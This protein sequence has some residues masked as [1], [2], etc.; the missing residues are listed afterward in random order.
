MS[1]N[2]ILARE[3]IQAVLDLGVREFILC[4]GARNS[5]FV[6]QLEQTTGI[7]LSSFFEERSAGF[8]AMGRAQ[9]SKRPVCVVTTSGTA[10]AE[11]LPASVEATYCQVPL[12]WL[13]ADRPR[14]YR[15]TGAPQTIHQPGIFSSYVEK[16]VD[17]E[18]ISELAAI[19]KWSGHKPLHLNVCFDEPL[20]D[21]PV[22]NLTAP[23]LTS[24]FLRRTI[25]PSTNIDSKILQNPFVILS[26]MSDEA[27]QIAKRLVLHFGWLHYAE[28]PSQLRGDPELRHLQVQSGD[29]ILPFAFRKAGF[30]SV[31]RFGSVP[32]LRFWRDLEYEFKS[33]P[34]LNLGE[35][36][37]SGL[38]R[39][40]QTA[41]LFSFGKMFEGDKSKFSWA[42]KSDCQTALRTED[43]RR[44]KQLFALF[45]KHPLS[46]PAMVFFFSRSLGKDASVYLGN[47]LPIRE[48][49]LAATY[50]SHF[51]RIGCNRGANG[52]D[53]QIS[54]FIGWAH[55]QKS[56]Y[57]LIGDLTALYDLT[58]LWA[59][60]ARPDCNYNVVVLN[61]GGGQIFK[62]IFGKD[63]FLNSHNLGFSHWAQM[64]QW[65][66]RRIE[67]GRQITWDSQGP[68]VIEL[69]PN[70][71]ETAQFWKAW[72]QV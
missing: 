51:S 37:Y 12:V 47:S 72:D 70:A 39:S 63:L 15:E 2:V 38:S 40:C 41:S 65:K 31:L 46:E 17:V 20:Q 32:T 34:V 54:S 9:E 27:A 69:C 26:G 58:S 53:G 36:P 59:A 48:W 29:K 33:L 7:S 43:D 1:R 35:T 22:T 21:G 5:P 23:T 55:P 10:V 56:N 13:T 4:A 42:Q 18:E 45:E 28:A 71:E 49:D 60:Q 6:L 30:Q 8:Y 57:A 50:D 11:L 14:A 62:R 67:D 64:W 19:N 24:A 68:Q 16:C 25:E 3:A 61:N 52:I 44:Q 66:Y